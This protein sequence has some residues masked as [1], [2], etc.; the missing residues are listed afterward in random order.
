MVV[1]ADSGALA[2]MAVMRPTP[3]LSAQPPPTH[4]VSALRNT[5]LLDVLAGKSTGRRCQPKKAPQVKAATA[6]RVPVAPGMV[7]C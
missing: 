6:A 1:K 3:P 2:G 7:D 4:T 5:T